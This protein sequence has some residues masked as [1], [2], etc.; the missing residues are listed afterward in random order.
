VADDSGGSE[1]IAEA[2]KVPDA[3]ATRRSMVKE[4]S[5]KLSHDWGIHADFSLRIW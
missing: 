1:A 2:G 3:L 4:L 5:E